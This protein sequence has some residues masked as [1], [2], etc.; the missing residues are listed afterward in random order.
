[1]PNL[2]A[3]LH[4][5]EIDVLY[6]TDGIAMLAIVTETQSMLMTLPQAALERLR[7]HIDD[8]L[9]REVAPSARR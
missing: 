6:L 4:A 1:M 9:P 7:S 2:G 5:Q 3:E 8:W